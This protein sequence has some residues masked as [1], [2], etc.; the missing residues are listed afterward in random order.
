MSDPKNILELRGEQALRAGRLVLNMLSRE[1]RPPENKV[2]PTK[3]VVETKRTARPDALAPVL[4][5]EFE[6]EGKGK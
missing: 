4:E 1:S 5:A 2:A 3:V 6:E